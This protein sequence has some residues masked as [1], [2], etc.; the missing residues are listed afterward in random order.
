MLFKELIKYASNQ[1]LGSDVFLLMM[2]D[3]VELLVFVISVFF[4]AM[5]KNHSVKSS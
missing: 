3:G 4:N 2:A 1:V 5:H